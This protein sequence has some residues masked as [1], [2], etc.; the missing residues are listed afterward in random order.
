M[1]KQAT[2]QKTASSATAQ[3]AGLMIQRQCA[4]GQHTVAGAPCSA[5]A[6][7]PKSLQRAPAS[8]KDTFASGANTQVPAAPARDFSRLPAHSRR[9]N[10]AGNPVFPFSNQAPANRSEKSDPLRYVAMPVPR[11]RVIN[12]AAKSS[13]SPSPADASPERSAEGDKSLRPEDENQDQSLDVTK[14]EA[15]PCGVSI[16][17]EAS[18][19]GGIIGGIA[20]GA[21]LGILGAGAGLAIGSAAGAVAGLGASL[22]IL[23][24]GAAVGG[25]IG[26][27]LAHNIFSFTQ[28]IN[29]NDPK[30]GSSSPYVDP[31]PNDDNKP[32][33]WTDAEQ[34]SYGNT[35]IDHPCRAKPSTGATNWDATMCVNSVNDK[36]VVAHD[37]ITYGFSRDATAKVTLR[38]PQK[39]GPSAHT[40][41]LSAEFP[42]WTFVTVEKTAP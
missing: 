11:L 12:F 32:F 14:F 7:Q 27:I 19:T 24:A 31:R 20:G 37:C 29:T 5:C 41:I 6:N 17:A 30:G 23:A 36:T 25:L 33:Y 35:F 15:S 28:T 1:S 26:G 21:A 39:T 10:Q 13:S 38:S 4:C 18:D 40:S 16:Q 42:G 2:A 34:A 3:S 8:G 22:G 9:T